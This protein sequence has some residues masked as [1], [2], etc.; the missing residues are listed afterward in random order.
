MGKE[1]TKKMIK[2]VDETIEKNKDFLKEVTKIRKDFDKISKEAEEYRKKLIEIYKQLDRAHS[3]LIQGDYADYYT[4]HLTPAKTPA[5]IDIYQISDEYCKLTDKNKKMFL[6][7]MPNRDT[8]LSKLS[9]LK[10]KLRDLVNEV[11]TL[12][13][14]IV[15][16]EDMEKICV[17]M[18][19]ISNK[20][21]VYDVNLCKNE[22]LNNKQFISPITFHTL[23]RVDP[24]HIQMY[25]DFMPVLKTIILLNEKTIELNNMLRKINS[26]LPFAE[27]K[28]SKPIITNEVTGIDKSTEIGE[29]ANIGKGAAIGDNAKVG[30]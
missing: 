7:Q 11:V 8:Y 1:L 27:L 26:N 18:D 28:E 29:K 21:W 9:E 14:F 25:L 12:N 19:S 10:S 30:N 6:E 15:R 3:M 16:F 5:F 22:I 17:E 4:V 24:F 20:H 23:Q 2:V 13:A